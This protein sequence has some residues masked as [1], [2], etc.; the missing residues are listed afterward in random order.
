MGTR[1]D[2]QFTG[3]EARPGKGGGWRCVNYS[4][5]RAVLSAVDRTRTRDKRR[6]ERLEKMEKI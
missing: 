3:L 1:V 4:L 2:R 6:L 5:A